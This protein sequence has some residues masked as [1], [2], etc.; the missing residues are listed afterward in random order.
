MIW[1]EKRPQTSVSQEFIRAVMT[2][3]E[4]GFIPLQN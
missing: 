2:K 1:N 4:W 3:N